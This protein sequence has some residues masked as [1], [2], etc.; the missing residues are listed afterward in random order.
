MAKIDI[1]FP[2]IL[3]FEG[4]FVNDP[5]DL[6]GATNKGVTMNTF[7]KYRNLVGKPIPSV[8]DL[9]AITDDEVM[10]IMKSFYWDK[11]K[12]DQIKCQSVAN[13]LVDW[14]WCSGT[15]AIKKSQGLLGTTADGIVGPATLGLVNNS[16]DQTRLFNSIQECRRRYLEDICRKRPANQKFLKGWMR[17][18]DSIQFGILKLNTVPARLISF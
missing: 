17:R 13:A 9:K 4:G 12:A 2:F 10:A 18:V 14:L 11:W 8:G 3:S 16:S 7:K 6:G 5:D 1:L 15:A